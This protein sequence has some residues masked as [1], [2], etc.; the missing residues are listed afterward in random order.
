MRYT[1]NQKIGKSNELKEFE[2]TKGVIRIRISK[3]DRQ[4]N[5]QKKNDKQRSTKHTHKTKDR[6]TRTPLK[7]G[8]N[9]GA[10]EG[11]AVPAPLETSVVLI[12]LKLTS[13]RHLQ[14]CAALIDKALFCLTSSQLHFSYIYD[15]NKQGLQSINHGCNSE[16][17]RC[18]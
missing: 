6:I 14:K 17:E 7:P 4:H 9:S 15:Q 16:K 10:S 18:G 1:Q 12:W 2:D 8:V 5:G 11:Y 3:K 13:P